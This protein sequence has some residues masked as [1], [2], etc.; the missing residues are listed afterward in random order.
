MQRPIVVQNTCPNIFVTQDPPRKCEAESGCL[1][2]DPVSGD[3][4]EH[5]V[6]PREP[7]HP[8][9][10]ELGPYF[11]ETYPTLEIHISLIKL[12]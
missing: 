3:T 4:R 1:T 10:V 6:P 8:W 9:K 5:V 11:W 2:S 12:S 7:Q